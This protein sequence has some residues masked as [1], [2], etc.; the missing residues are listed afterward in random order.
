MNL[1]D[2]TSDFLNGS[3][4]SVFKMIE[5]QQ[6]SVDLERNMTDEFRKALDEQIARFS[7]PSWVRRFITCKVLASQPPRLLDDD[8]LKPAVTAPRSRE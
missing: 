6:I 8:G 5:R 4:P 7:T 2:D 1:L 3:G